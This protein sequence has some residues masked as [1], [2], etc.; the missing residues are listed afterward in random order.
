MA[1]ETYLVA[2][3]DGSVYM[4]YS[5]TA[6][7]LATNGGF[8][9][10]ADVPVRMH[11]G[12][13][14]PNFSSPENTHRHMYFVDG[15]DYWRL[16]AHQN[17]AFLWYAHNGTDAISGDTIAG[18]MPVDGEGNTATMIALYRN[19][20]VLAGLA[21]DPANWFM[22]AV[23]DPA[24]W[25]YAP[26]TP[27]A[28]QAV[29]GN[30]SDAGEVGDRITALAP[31]HDDL[32]VMGGDQSLWVMRGDPQAGGTLDAISY[33]TGIV[34]PDAWAMDPGG[35]MY[36]LGQ[37]GLFRFTGGEPQMLSRGRLDRALRDIDLSAA[38][39]VLQW[40]RQRDGLWIFE[41]RDSDAEPGLHYF[42][43][44]RT[45]GFWPIQL[46]AGNGPF[47][48]T[49][50]DTD[51]AKDRKMLVGGLDGFVRTFVDDRRDDSAWDSST[52][53]AI[54]AAIPSHLELGPITG[55][56][57]QDLR[58]NE[59]V[60]ILDDA[61]APVTVGIHADNTAE[62]LVG[63]T[64]RFNSQLVAGRNGS[65]RRRVRGHAMK[66]RVSQEALGATWSLEDAAVRLLPA[67]RA[68]GG[69][70]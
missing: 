41:A 70:P 14:S 69:T 2:V 26:P 39:V 30:N 27:T 63:S 18:S 10:A 52:T 48:A 25:D 56:A 17:E 9:F 44:R 7:S 55:E 38:R 15:A 53:A 21:E 51:A 67:G 24:N 32:M 60:F 62:G 42:W 8:L 54:D 3:S 33:Q 20:I 50:F 16:D 65:I 34:G 22:S 31:L 12:P 37:P 4:G 43:D 29:A 1:R 35:A 49:T 11:D 19:R 13:P 28:T 58:V 36:F 23:G 64:P 5:P 61:G 40:D 68:R 66:L 46:P 47:C 59:L 45:D 57:G 6:M